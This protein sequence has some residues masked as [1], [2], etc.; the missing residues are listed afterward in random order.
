MN[1]SYKCVNLNVLKQEKSHLEQTAEI[2]KIMNDLNPP[3][4]ANKKNKKNKKK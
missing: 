1:K 2:D 3:P 4:V